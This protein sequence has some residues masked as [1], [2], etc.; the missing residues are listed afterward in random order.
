MTYMKQILQEQ[1]VYFSGLSPENLLSESKSNKVVDVLTQ[2]ANQDPKAA[3]LKKLV[4]E[5]EDIMSDEG[6]L[7]GSQRNKLWSAVL[8]ILRVL[9]DINYA[10]NVGATVGVAVGAAAIGVLPLVVPLIFKSVLFIAIN[11]LIRYGIN[12]VEHVNERKAA[13]K[14]LSELK[15]LEKKV[16]QKDKGVIRTQ[17]DK[18]EKVLKNK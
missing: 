9:V 1:S 6:E 17:I 18:M 13:I 4:I 12:E 5:A 11:R 15:K 8:A 10:F 16:P 14:T 2:F 7:S 3:R